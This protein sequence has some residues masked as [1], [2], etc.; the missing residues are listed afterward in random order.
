MSRPLIHGFTTSEFGRPFGLPPAESS[1]AAV[2]GGTSKEPPLVSPIKER[3]LFSGSG[4]A[5]VTSTPLV[6]SEKISS[7]S[8]PSSRGSPFCLAPLPSKP[9]IDTRTAAPSSIQERSLSAKKMSPPPLI[10]ASTLRLAPPRMEFVA[11]SPALR[12][13]P[14]CIFARAFSNQ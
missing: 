6:R 13:S 11:S 7:T 12:A 10:R 2:S 5:P 3:P 4:T 8:T 1:L 9:T 14:L